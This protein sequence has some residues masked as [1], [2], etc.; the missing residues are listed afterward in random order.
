MNTRAVSA[1]RT[2]MRKIRPTM[3]KYADQVLRT[4]NRK[5]LK[6]FDKLK[7]IPLDEVNVVQSVANAY[8]ETAI[9]ARKRYFD[10]IYHA[11]V[12]GQDAAGVSE[13]KSVANAKKRVTPDLVLEMMIDYDEVALYQF[14]HEAE[15][16]Q[17]RLVE[18]MI[19]SHNKPEEID[20][21]LRQWTLQIARYADKSVETGL[22]L[23]YKDAGV[24]QVKW[25]AIDDEKTCNPCFD[26]NGKVYPI[27]GVPP[28]P[29]YHCRCELWP[30]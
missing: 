29:H 23:G 3:Y 6:V 25:I 22:L 24:R 13:T 20:R 4:L 12:F 18:A 26:R 8:R 14:A 7:L 19:A 30:V 2:T 17:Q 1:W 10:I 16:K 15:R 9:L 11:Y 21:A 5:N 27:D 28:R